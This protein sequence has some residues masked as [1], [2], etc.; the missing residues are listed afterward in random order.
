MGQNEFRSHHPRL[1]VRLRLEDEP[2]A[3][4]HLLQ[5]LMVG[6]DAVV[7]HQELVGTVGGVGVAVVGRGGTVCGPPRVSDAAVVLKVHL[8]VEILLCFHL[9]FGRVRGAVV[10]CCVV[11]R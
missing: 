11:G 9:L 6:D 5:R 2:A 4:Q 3:L 1:S 10:G 8:R 7:H